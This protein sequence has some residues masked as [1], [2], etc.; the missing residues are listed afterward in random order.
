MEYSEQ[1]TATRLLEA[2]R[3]GDRDALNDLF[4]L[5]YE[6]LRDQARSQRRNWKGDYTLNTT[7]MVHEAYLKLVEQSR[8]NWQNRAHF[9]SV[10][11]RAMRYILLD[12]AKHRQAKKRG[13][14][15]KKVSIDLVPVA[16]DFDIPEEKADALVAL[17]E[18]L[19]QLADLSKRQ[20]Q[21]VECRF[22]GGMTIAD[23]AIALEI[24]TATVKRDWLIAQAWLYRKMIG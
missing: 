22:F 9:L 6:E 18:A 7:A 20:S 24:S 17:N 23:T 4:P 13:G 8:M 2:V 14:E 1:L 12:Y 15:F 16:G 19:D 10:A 21:V 11:A 3:A 5:V